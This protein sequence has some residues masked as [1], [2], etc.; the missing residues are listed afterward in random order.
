LE[1]NTYLEAFEW[2]IRG[3]RDRGADLI[4]LAGYAATLRVAEL[5]RCEMVEGTVE[6]RSGTLACQASQGLRPTP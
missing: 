6:G 5:P 2:L 4:D 3:W 1:G